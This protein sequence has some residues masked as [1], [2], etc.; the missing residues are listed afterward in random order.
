MSTDA[1]DPDDI[2]A[3]LMADVHLEAVDTSDVIDVSKLSVTDLLDMSA[4]ITGE[5]HEDGQ[6]LWPKDQYH[7]DLHSLRNSIQIELLNRKKKNEG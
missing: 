3:S 7:R 5:L 4:D 2:F 6:A 1:P